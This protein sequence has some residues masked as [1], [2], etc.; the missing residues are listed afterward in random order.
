M[1]Q[2]TVGHATGDVYEAG[3]DDPGDGMPL[4][5]W[6][7]INDEVVTSEEFARRWRAEFQADPVDADAQPKPEAT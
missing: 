6:T 3:Y 1:T 5:P 4:V 7:R 2:R